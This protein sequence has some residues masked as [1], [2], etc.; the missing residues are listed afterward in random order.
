MNKDRALSILLVDDDEATLRATSL[1]LRSEGF[2]VGSATTRAA[3]LELAHTR[4]FELVV[5]DFLL[6]DCD[7]LELARELAQ[8]LN[9][10]S[11]LLSGLADAIPPAVLSAAGCA[12]CLTKPVDIDV[13][14]ETIVRVL[15]PGAAP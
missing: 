9:L 1:V 14:M 13:L 5:C 10:K 6:P 4:R 3:A 2:E 15:R 11:I 12:A 8:R 7:G